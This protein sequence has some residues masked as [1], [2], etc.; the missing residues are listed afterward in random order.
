MSIPR[1]IM[2]RKYWFLNYWAHW[3][4]LRIKAKGI[5]PMIVRITLLLVIELLRRVVRLA[6]TYLK[7]EE[8]DMAMSYGLRASALESLMIRCMRGTRDTWT[9]GSRLQRKKPRLVGTNVKSGLYTI[10]YTRI[11]EYKSDQQKRQKGK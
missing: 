7:V 11:T 6:E 10:E 9:F 1:F 4:L 3:T 8:L 2:G 5:R